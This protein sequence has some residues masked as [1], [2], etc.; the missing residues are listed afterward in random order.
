MPINSSGPRPATAL[1]N[2][3][4]A[5]VYLMLGFGFQSCYAILNRQMAEQLSLSATDVGI[6]SSTYTWCFAIAQLFS[7]A[8]LDRLGAR[9]ILPKACALLAAGIFCFAWSGGLF[10]LVIAQVLVAAGSSFG[11]VGA[12]FVSRM[13]FS[14]QRY[15]LMF[16]LA[17]FAVSFFAFTCQ[18][19]LARG[20]EG[21]P[22]AWV[23]SGLGVVGVI[24]FIAMLLCLRDPPGLDGA[25]CPVTSGLELVKCLLRG[26]VQ[27]IRIPGVLH[28]ILIGA[29]SF[30]AMLSLSAVWGPRL[31]MAQGLPEE[32]AGAAVSLGWL[33][34]AVG[35]PLIV[36]WSRKYDREKAAIM[37][38]L[39][40]QVLCVSLALLVKTEA[41]WVYSLLMLFWGIGVGANML[42]FVLAARCAGEAYTG[43]AMALVNCGQFLAGGLLVYIPGYLLDAAPGM[44][45]TG[46]LLILPLSLSATLLLCFR[47]KVKTAC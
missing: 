39:G 18:Q 46:A 16:S 27:V 23:I 40:M 24:L 19:S 37:L 14:P 43:T 29:A 20:L 32:S 15:G 8:L 2:W 21:V 25:A 38:G 26:V 28:I 31:L 3:G 33:G 1:A 6:V 42:P 10:G 34:L 17:Q 45:I 36:W 13:W 5:V 12:G 22:Y 47:L 11:F 9:R 4:I 41:A 35:A 30:G 7:G 44:G